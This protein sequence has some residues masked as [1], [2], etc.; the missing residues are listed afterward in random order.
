MQTS[1]RTV[2][3]LQ[4]RAV[5]QRT[6]PSG[7]WAGPLAPE[8]DPLAG[9][10]STSCLHQLVQDVGQSDHAARHQPLIAHIH[11]AAAGPAQV[12]VNAIS[13][14]WIARWLRWVVGTKEPQQ[15]CNRSAASRCRCAACPSTTPAPVQPVGDNLVQ[16]LVQRGIRAAGAGRRDKCGSKPDAEQ[17]GCI[18]W[19]T[20]ARCKLITAPL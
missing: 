19:H 16:H 6:R 15:R 20:L 4:A 2:E 8:L 3:Q 1:G 5:A 13:A 9:L 12:G 18:V 17:P 14:C 11:P 7:R 10:H